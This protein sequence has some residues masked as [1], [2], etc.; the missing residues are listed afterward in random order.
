[1]LVLLLSMPALVI[2]QDEEGEVVDT[3]ITSLNVDTMAAPD[4]E[5]VAETPVQP[6]LRGVPD[7]SVNQLKNQKAFAYANDSAY[8][9]KKTRNPPGAAKAFGITSMTFSPANPFA[10]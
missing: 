3:V 8:W 6:E 9:G 4:E 5:P 1:M 10:S 2:A 7:S